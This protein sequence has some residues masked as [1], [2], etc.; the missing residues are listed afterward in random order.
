MFVVPLVVPARTDKPASPR[1]RVRA[2]VGPN[3][4]FWLYAWLVCGVAACVLIPAARG[5]EQLG[6]TVPFW[7]V[8]A[9]SMNIVWLRRARWIAALRRF[10]LHR[11]RAGM[12]VRQSA[13]PTTARSRNASKLRLHAP[14]NRA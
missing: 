3:R 8:A 11:S 10:R 6:A 9:P 14:A 2:V 1:R 4:M 5:S 7:L 12:A 13:S